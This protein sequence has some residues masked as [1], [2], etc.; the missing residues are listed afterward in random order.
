MNIYKH[1]LSDDELDRIFRDSAE[2]TAFGFDPDSWAK[3]SQKLDAVNV[4][5]SGQNQTKNNW[6]KRGLSVFLVLLFSIGVY[7]FIIPSLKQAETTLQAKQKNG[8][9]NESKANSKKDI[10]TNNVATDNLKNEVLN[11]KPI[12][13]KNANDFEPISYEKDIVENKIDITIKSQEDLLVDKKTLNSSKKQE[14]IIAKNESL[15]ESLTKQSLVKSKKT[16]ETNTLFNNSLNNIST[17]K[18]PSE[19]N[20]VATENKIKVISGESKKS[21]N[22]KKIGLLSDE[23]KPPIINNIATQDIDNQIFINTSHANEIAVISEATTERWQLGNIKNL[24]PKTSSFKSNIN[25][26]IIAFESPKLAAT[27]PSSKN[28]SF[29]KGFNLRLAISPDLSLVTINE[30]TRLGSNWAAL[31][32]YRFNNHLS[33][34]T[35]VIRSMKYYD[36]FPESYTWP[37]NW[38]QPPMLIDINATCKMLDIPLNIRYDITQKANNRLFVSAGFT[39]YIMLNEKYT[40]NYENPYD[41]KIKWRKWQG[42]TGPYYFSVLNLSFGYEHQVFRKLSIQAEPFVKVPIGKVGFGKVNLSTIGIF[43]SAK[44]PINKA[45]FSVML[46]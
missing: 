30:I 10:A 33:L 14:N 6:S 42:K 40:Y 44:Y 21:I 2:N 13:K 18:I 11:Q 7:Y 37:Y 20:L 38:S 9:I 34:Q 32:E 1:D 5:A 46:K 24:T 8:S 45:K 43:I 17:N 15:G 22:T 31:L 3:M 28:N 12:S 25:L 35:G 29:K 19:T 4:P 16:S 36:S 41:P 39:S 26:P 23:K 27:I